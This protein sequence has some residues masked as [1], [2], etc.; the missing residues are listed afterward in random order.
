M[1]VCPTGWEFQRIKVEV[2]A[3]ALLRKTAFEMK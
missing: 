2:A 3:G 1:V